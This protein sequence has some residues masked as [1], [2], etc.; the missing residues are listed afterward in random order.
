MEEAV[1][2][3][4]GKI[5]KSRSVCFKQFCGP[6]AV[7]QRA[8]IF[9]IILHRKAD[10]NRI[11][12]ANRIPYC[13]QYLQCQ[14]E[15][16]FKGFTGIFS[17]GTVIGQRRKKLAQKINMA[18]FDLNTVKAGTFCPVCGRGKVAYDLIQ[19][20]VGQFLSDQPSF[21]IF[22]RVQTLLQFGNRPAAAVI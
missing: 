2:G 11:V 13:L 10:R 17:A 16:C 20:L 6:D 5:Q 19:F 4:A 9:I 22:F 12:L 1:S 18:G 15:A 7:L 21:R 3:T 14:T 8:S